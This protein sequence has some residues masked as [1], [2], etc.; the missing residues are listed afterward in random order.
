[1]APTRRAGI[2]KIGSSTTASNVIC[3]D[4]RSITPSVSTS[5]ITLVTTP[6]S[7]E[8]KARWAPITSLL[9]RLTSAPVWVRVKKAIGMPCTWPNTLRR[10]S[11]IRPS[12]RLDDMSRSSRPTAGVEHGDQRD[13]RAPSTTT[14]A[15]RLAV[16]DG[17]DGPAGEQRGGHADHGRRRWPAA[18]TW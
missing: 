6:D 3:H 12:P 1:M 14:R 17:V 10:R 5:T 8:V 2:T 11:R 13:Q 7:A 4:S 15:A 16:D 18:G 9:S